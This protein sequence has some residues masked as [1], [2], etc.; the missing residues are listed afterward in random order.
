MDSINAEACVL[1]CILLDKES[2]LTVFAEL[3]EDDFS[4][5]LHKKIY[6]AFSKL[7]EKEEPIDLVTTMHELSK[8]GMINE[9]K[10]RLLDINEMVSSTENVKSY[11]SIVRESSTLRKLKESFKDGLKKVNDCN[12]TNKIV[13]ETMDAICNVI[14]MKT[15]SGQAIEHTLDDTLK[16]I[17]DVSTNSE[18][19]LM[20]DT[21]LPSLNKSIGRLAGGNLYILAARPA[22]GK[23]SLAVNMMKNIAEQGGV[24]AMFSL[25]MTKQDL[26]IRM[27]GSDARVSSRLL[28]EGNLNA[29]QVLAITRST[30]SLK[31]LKIFVDDTGG[32]THFDINA[33]A[34]NIKA[35]Y[36]KL[37][38]LVIDYIQLMSSVKAFN[39]RNSEIEDI[40]KNLKAI[41][42]DLN[43]P[44][45]ALSQLNRG[46]EARE[47]KRPRLSDLRDSGAIEQDADVVLFIYRDEYYN[48][49]TNQKDIAEIIPAKN[50][51]GGTDVV[52]LIFE[53]E[54]TEFREIT[55][56]EL[57]SDGLK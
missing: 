56:S 24:C 29:D 13:Q 12:D 17:E 16:Y 4:D 52:E 26:N 35:Y 19:V 1:S 43:V 7:Y 40:T 33:R 21:G 32:L 23:T 36:G 57:F 25:E 37:D 49:H 9:H 39:S 5:G 47:D 31:S 53:N 30:D 15:S 3:N 41:A 48:K 45:L 44:I 55:S 18:N 27:I 10:M 51:H 38:F 14:D 46:V 34:K 8:S 28:R 54:F 20:L 22:M 6:R 50:R 11:I 42:K 2:S